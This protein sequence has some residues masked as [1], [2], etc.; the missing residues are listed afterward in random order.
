M[1][2]TSVQITR[3]DTTRFAIV[4]KGREVPEGTEALFTV[5]KKPWRHDEVVIQKTI[6]VVSGKVNVFL[7][8]YETKIEPGSYVWDV[9]IKEPYDG[10]TLVLTPMG[11]GGFDVLEAIGD[12]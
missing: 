1:E 3:G 6:P 10:D 12:E 4:L 8:P 7:E 9:R 11:Y 2:G 5:K